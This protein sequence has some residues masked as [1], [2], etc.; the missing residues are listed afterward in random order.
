MES[1]DARVLESLGHDLVRQT[2][3]FEIQLE[4]GDSLFGA[5][6]LAIHVAKGVFPTDDISEQLVAA[7]RVL[8]VVI[9]ADADAD[10]ANGAGKW[11]AC[12]HE[13][14]G[15]AANGGH[16]TGAVGFENFA[17]HAD[18]VRIFL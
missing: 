15:A 8:V 9:S 18:G 17:G 12:I 5:G 7:D 4:A 10:A 14:E 3:Q 2:A 16:R 6:D 13:G 11:N 1:G